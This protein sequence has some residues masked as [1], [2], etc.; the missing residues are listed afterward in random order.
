[1]FC[2]CRIL[3][4]NGRN[5]LKSMKCWKWKKTAK[6]FT[7]WAQCSLGQSIL[8]LDKEC[9][10]MIPLVEILMLLFYCVM[11]NHFKDELL[12]SAK[13]CNLR[14]YVY[15]WMSL[16]F[17]YCSWFFPN[18]TRWN[19]PQQ[20]WPFSSSCLSTLIG[21]GNNFGSWLL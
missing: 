6:T 18:S 11:T 19:I 9:I 12:F 15:I 8:C 7:V 3:V 4:W 21:H 13:T 14:L 16:P 10:H 1:M 5:F 20:F 17:R 2:K